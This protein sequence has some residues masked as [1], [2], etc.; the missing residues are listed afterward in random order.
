MNSE[1]KEILRLGAIVASNKLMNVQM[2]RIRKVYR[3]QKRESAR[4]IC[5]VMC[6]V[7]SK[8]DVASNFME[9]KQEESGSASCDA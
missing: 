1:G 4:T 3:K 2:T 8:G 6:K 9:I 7:T 5:K